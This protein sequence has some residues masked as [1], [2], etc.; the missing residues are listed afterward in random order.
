MTPEPRNVVTDM[1]REGT[2]E[3]NRSLNDPGAS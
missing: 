3:G 2:R 1:L